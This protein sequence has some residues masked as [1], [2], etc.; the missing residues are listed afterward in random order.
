[1][2][3]AVIFDI[4]GVLEYTPPLGTDRRWQERLGLDRDEWD[5][6]LHDVWKAGSL[7]AISEVEVHLRLGDAL[8]VTP[9][10]VDDLMADLWV[11]Y[12][13]TPNVE[14]I[15]YARSLRRS[16]RTG[17]L[18][19][20]FVGASGREQAAYGFADLVDVL[21]YSHEV[22]I[23]KPDPR[24][25]ALTCERLGVCPEQS[26]FVDDHEPC[27]D[28]ARAAGLHAVRF[29]DNAQAIA[30]IEA[31]LGGAGSCS[32]TGDRSSTALPDHQT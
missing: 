1:M 20:S 12:L 30:E 5:R 7:G 32:A 13:G 4:G 15:E 27:V 10:V 25:Y 31:I 3:R 6:R 9:A 21:V 17:I 22:G 11:E 14:L 8:G 28:A 18:S 26:V 16:Y 24:I 19:N 29:V 23:Q 2:I